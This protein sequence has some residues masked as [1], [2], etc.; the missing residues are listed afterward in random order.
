[1]A[2]YQWKGISGGQ[3]GDGKIEAESLDEAKSQL[4][5]KKI[6]FT[7]L[8]L[9]SGKEPPSSKSKSTKS[10][11]AS[12]QKASAVPVTPAKKSK[13]KKIKN[14]ELMIFT[15]KFATMIQSG[16]PILKT[17]KM[18]ESQTESKNFKAVVHAILTD[19]ESGSTLSDAFEKHQ[20]VFDSV[21]I[22][23][24]RAG[25]TSGK[26]PTFLN[27]LVIQIEKSEK[28]RSKVKG[29]LT[30]PTILVIVA[31]VVIILMLVKVVPVFQQMF[32]SMGHTL[33]KP[34]L[35]IIAMSDFLRNPAQGGTM[36]ATI[37]GLIFGLKFLIKT[38]YNIRY[39]FHELYLKIPLVKDIIQRSTLS[40]IAMIEGNL[41]AAGV[42]VLESL[43]IIAKSVSNEVYRKAL[44][45]VKTGISEGRTLSSLYM[46]NK[47]FNDTFCQMIAVGEETGN[48]DEMFDATARYFEEEFDMTVNR[49]T[50]LLEPLMIVFMGTTIGFIIIAMYMPIFQIGQTMM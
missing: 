12:N 38:N 29:A 13:G 15:K 48:M 14:R 28:I 19:V 31:I 27:K 25:E 20:N 16:L 18:L 2:V 50:E 47:V 21:Y 32:S 9:I 35:M 37:L 49:M 1:M 30:Y 10:S 23:L 11:K 3:H 46:E 36:I 4:R 22:N 5:K 43:D 7:D 45:D 6:I 26:L 42:S 40:K 41:S 39:K 34:T 24:L 8:R 17:L 44:V 33:P